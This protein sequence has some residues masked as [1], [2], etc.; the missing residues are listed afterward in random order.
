M[1]R[2][3]SLTIL[4][5]ILFG[6]SLFNLLGAV[7]VAQRWEFLRQ[8]PLAVSPLY[9]AVGDAFWAVVLAALTLGL[10]RRLDW[11]RGATLPAFLGYLAHGWLNRLVFARAD[12]VAT[13]YGWVA[14]V[15][16]ASALL[17]ALSVWR[18]TVRA[19]FNSRL[20]SEI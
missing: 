10:W 13:T 16:V 6:L 12:F 17:V 8:Q 15:D 18:P 11:A 14:A 5:I 19:W 1:R 3:R 7:S 2:P 4:C 9:L 20:K